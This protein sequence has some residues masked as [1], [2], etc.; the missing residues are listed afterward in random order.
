MTC[1]H[2]YMHKHVRPG[3]AQTAGGEVGVGP[4]SVYIRRQCVCRVCMYTLSRGLQSTHIT[5]FS[6]WMGPNPFLQN[7]CVRMCIRMS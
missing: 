3:P 7:M 4:R 6:F 2:V 1:V 5:G